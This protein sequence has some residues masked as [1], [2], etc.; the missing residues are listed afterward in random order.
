VTNFL[1]YRTV[2]GLILPFV[3]VIC[4]LLAG[5]GQ[6]HAT[7]NAMVEVG[8]VGVPPPGFQN[9]LLNVQQ[10]RINKNATAAPDNGAWQVIPV[11]PGI[12]NS[13]QKAELQID[14]N[15]SQN[16][17]QLFNTAGVQP[18]TYLVAELDLD[19]N[20]PGT[21]VPNC[22]LAPP[23]GSTADGCINYP[24]QLTVGTNVISTLISGVAPKKNTVAVL[25]LQVSLAINSAPTVPG[26]PYTATVTIAPLPNS[27]LGTVTGSLKVTTGSGTGTPTHL[28][29]LSVTAETI[30]TNTPISTALVT[31]NNY[32]LILPAAGGPAA[33]GFGT[34]YD[35]AVSGG[36]DSYAAQRL[37]PLYPGQ[38]IT[39]DPLDV[40]S[41]QTLGNIT[42]TVTDGCVATK[43]IAGATLQLLMPPASNPSAVCTIAPPAPNPCV[44]VATANTDNAGNFPLPGTVITPAAFDQVPIL[45]KKGSYV[46]EVTAPG[47]DPLFVQAI[48]S[49]NGSSKDGTCSVNGGAFLTCDLTMNTGYITGSIPITPPNPGQST[50]V[51]VFAEDA[52]TNNIES[53]LP[54]PISVNSSNTGMVNFTLNVPPSVPIFDLFAT[55]IDNYQ[56]VSDPFQGHTIAV[57]SGVTG[58][59]EP[60]MPGA[61]ST[62]TAAPFEDQIECVGHGSVSGSVANADLGTTVELSKQDPESGDFVQITNSPVQNQ[63][64]NPNA[65]NNYSFCAPADTYGLQRVQLPM[66]T[67]SETPVVAPTPEPEG[68]P[69]IIVTIPPPPIINGQTPTPSTTPTGG[70]TPTATPTQKV[71]CPTT[72]SVPDGGCPGICNPVIKGIP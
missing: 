36:A 20:N 70:P 52:G 39:V 3:I 63:S 44:T 16:L 21:L 53:A 72:C 59:A 64:P 14:L 45:P 18:N 66:P 68:T 51:Q 26:G 11:P 24:I 17:P 58:P 56:G 48:P 54:M 8:F 43:P 32:T 22:P 15:T 33:P 6:A 57:E 50:L 10:V 35:L 28:L 42:G 60:S 9:V 25:V 19:P 29:P 4:V 65:S 46:M 71:T 2:R 27:V 23:L 67:E 12:G 47:Y 40:T 61:C 13:E 31:N 69:S 55:T 38:S 49:S 5:F 1:A 41:A 7:K 34:L 62:V 30:G 37:Q